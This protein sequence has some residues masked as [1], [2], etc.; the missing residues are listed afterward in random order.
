MKCKH[1]SIEHPGPVGAFANH[2]RW[3]DSNPKAAAFRAANAERGQA[4]GDKRFGE[5]QQ[6]NV[7]CAACAGSM[8]V[9]ERESLFPSKSEYFCS[10]SCANSIGGKAKALKHHGTMSQDM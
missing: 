3:C 7:T 6:Y 9:E 4:L 5:Y 8:V 10:R 1:C 2:V